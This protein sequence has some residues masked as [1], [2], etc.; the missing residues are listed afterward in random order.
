M[1]ENFL[2][3]KKMPGKYN[4]MKIRI[5]QQEKW[6]QKIYI[7]EIEEKEVQPK[8]KCGEKFMEKK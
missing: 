8:R 7:K 5:K 6:N 1:K 4:H 2:K 3:E